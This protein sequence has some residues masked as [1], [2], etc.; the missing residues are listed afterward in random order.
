MRFTVKLSRVN[1]N[2]KKAK[3]ACP[4]ICLRAACEGAGR[5]ALVGGC[6]QHALQP[7][8]LQRLRPCVCSHLLPP[9]WNWSVCYSAMQSKAK[10][11]K[12]TCEGAVLCSVQ[13]HTRAGTLAEAGPPR[14]PPLAC[15]SRRQASQH[16]AACENSSRCHPLVCR[17]YG[18]GAVKGSPRQHKVDRHDA[19][20]HVGARAS[21]GVRAGI[22]QRERSIARPPPCTAWRQQHRPATYCALNNAP[23]KHAPHFSL[24]SKR[25][26]DQCFTKGR[27]HRQRTR[28]GMNPA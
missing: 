17:V 16:R 7:L 24:F 27:F 15:T 26:V 22:E 4:L 25:F 10:Q 19:P 20:E 21:R 6:I 5:A 9:H 14:T 28:A 13:W 18:K 1:T 12:R 8:S 2:S 11:S 3:L 23:Q